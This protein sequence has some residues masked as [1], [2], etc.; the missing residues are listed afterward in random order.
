MPCAGPLDLTFQP[1]LGKHIFAENMFK[2]IGDIKSY[3]ASLD[4]SNLGLDAASVY[5]RAEKTE[6]YAGLSESEA[7][8]AAEAEAYLISRAEKGGWAPRQRRTKAHRRMNGRGA[9]DAV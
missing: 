3:A 8:R 9:L 7:L 4:P 6:L 5:C 2:T 1:E